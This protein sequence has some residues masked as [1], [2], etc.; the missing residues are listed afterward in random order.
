VLLAE[1]ETELREG[2]VNDVADAD[3]IDGEQDTNRVGDDT[4]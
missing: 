3:D 4:R 1:E 2:G